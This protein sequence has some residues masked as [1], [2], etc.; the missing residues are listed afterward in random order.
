VRDPATAQICESVGRGDS[1]SEPVG[2]EYS[3]SSSGRCC[4]DAARSVLP[5]IEKGRRVT[6]KVDLSVSGRGN[7]SKSTVEYIHAA[8]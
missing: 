6:M 7:S 2:S 3:C 5:K 8:A 1:N 4:R